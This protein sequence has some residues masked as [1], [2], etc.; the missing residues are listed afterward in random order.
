VLLPVAGIPDS[1]MTVCL[2]IIFV[3]SLRPV[4]LSVRPAKTDYISGVSGSD[5]RAVADSACGVGGVSGA[6]G[7]GTAA[8][9]FFR[10]FVAT[11]LRPAVRRLRVAAA[12]RPAARCLRVAAAFLAAALCLRV[13]AAFFPALFRLGLSSSSVTIRKEI[14]PEVAS[15]CKTC[16]S[17]VPPK[18]SLIL[19]FMAGSR[20]WLSKRKAAFKETAPYGGRS[21]YTATGTLWRVEVTVSHV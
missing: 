21:P 16:L 7:C 3:L 18:G 1:R 6:A 14:K 8:G 2:G 20:M 4:G 5:D 12:L 19:T 9:C 11:A 10:A 15:L 17:F 13:A